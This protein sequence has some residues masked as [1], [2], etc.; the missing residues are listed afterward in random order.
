IAKVRPEYREYL[1]VAKAV[2]HF[3]SSP[4]D[5]DPEDLI[6]SGDSFKAGPDPI[7][8][9]LSL[10]PNDGAGGQTS[11]PRGARGRVKALD[12]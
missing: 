8:K 4:D 9:G 2:W 10:G 6:Y 7:S 11:V 3:Q 1:L 5:F 12:A